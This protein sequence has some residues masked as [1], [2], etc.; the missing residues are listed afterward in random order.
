[1]LKGLP[2]RGHSFL[3]TVHRKYNGLKECTMSGVSHL[4]HEALWGMRLV[5]SW[6]ER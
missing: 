2:L 3:L 1:M 5:L 4:L 6:T